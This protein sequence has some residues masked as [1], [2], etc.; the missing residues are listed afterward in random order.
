MFDDEVQK[1]FRRILR[2]C[3]VVWLCFGIQSNAEK[4]FDEEEFVDIGVRLIGSA[5]DDLMADL[6]AEEKDLLHHGH[7][8]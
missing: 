6:I 5:P 4:N 1:T 7:V 2:I 8:R 3:L